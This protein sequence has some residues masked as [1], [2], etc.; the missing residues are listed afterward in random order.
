MAAM[1][2]PGLPERREPSIG[3]ASWFVLPVASFDLFAPGRNA[4]RDLAGC[5]QGN[6][7]R[8]PFRHF[9]IGIFQ[10]GVFQIKAKQLP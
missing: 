4:A 1:S 10:I 2:G 3:R 5:V 7:S 9:Q 6:A 8:L